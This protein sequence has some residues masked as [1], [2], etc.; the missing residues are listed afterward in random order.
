MPQNGQW[1]GSVDIGT[2]PAGWTAVGAGDFDGDGV[3]DIMW[4]NRS[5]GHIENW[6]LIAFAVLTLVVLVRDLRGR[7]G[8][9]IR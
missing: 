1:V 9:W 4:F 3:N 8:G 6:I 7:R 5:T 2:H